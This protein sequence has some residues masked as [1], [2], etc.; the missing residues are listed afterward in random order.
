M[1]RVLVVQHHFL[2]VHNVAV[3]R[4]LGYARHLPALG[5]EPVFLARDWESADDADPSWGLVWQPG[6]VAGAGVEIQRAPQP[7]GPARRPLPGP[8]RGP[9]GKALAKARRLRRLLAG[10]YPDE[11]VGWC[12]P[13]VEAGLALARRTTVHAIASYCPP[14][15]NHVVASRLARALDVP[16]VP[17][18]GDLASFLVPPLPRHSLE[19]RLRTARH[20]GWLAPAAAAAAASPAMAAYVHDTYGLRTEVI[21]T[22]LDPL[23]AP[24]TARGDR[25]VVSHVGSIYPGDQR[26]ELLLDG[27]DLLL[28]AQP[29]AA[30]TLRVRL[31]GSKCDGTLRTLLR[32]RPAGLVCEVEPLGDPATARRIV[33]ESDGLLALT[34]TAHRDRH[35]TLSYPTKLFEA[36]GARRPILAVPADG[37]WVD[38]LLATTGGGTSASDPAAIAAV[39]ADWLAHWRSDGHVPW[40]GRTA[41]LAPLERREQA[42]RL[43]RLLDSVAGRAT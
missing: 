13:A 40:H 22:G 16:W 23:D 17:F 7:P 15:T 38:E 30:R 18:F 3:G 29:D 20:A 10:P 24:A 9:T 5:W 34:C 4:M 6:L 28:A 39:L 33:A 26:P 19:R 2:P 43:A 14:V 11:L 32:G 8:G 25:C 31:V 42:A 36:L 21:L 12:G 27:L 1:H 37:D 35:G 41:A